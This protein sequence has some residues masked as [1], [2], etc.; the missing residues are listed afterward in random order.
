MGEKKNYQY[1]KNKFNSLEN[2]LQVTLDNTIT[3][4]NNYEDTSP[5]DSGIKYKQIEEKLIELETTEYNLRREMEN[6]QL[7]RIDE[8][9]NDLEI[10]EDGE[11]NEIKNEKYKQMLKDRINMYNHTTSYGLILTASILGMIYLSLP[12]VKKN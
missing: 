7:T 2:N 5:D 1:F 12:L 6:E 4:F 11:T 10:S 8:L 3:F 9:I